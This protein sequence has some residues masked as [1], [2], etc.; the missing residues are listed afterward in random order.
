MGRAR[1]RRRRRVHRPLHRRH[2][3]A[4]AP[5]RGRQEGHHLGAGQER[6]HHH[7]HRRERRRLRRREA[8]H[9]LQR[10]V[11]HQLPRAVREG[12]AR[13][14]RHQARL[15]EHDPQLHQRPEHPRLA[16]QGPA[17]CARG[18][19]VDHPDL[20]RRRQGHRPRHAG[21]EGQARR[22]VDACSHAGRL[23]RRPGVRARDL[24][25]QR[26]HQRRDEGRCRRSDEGHPRVLRGADRLDRRR[27]QPGILGLRLAAD[28]GHGRGGHVR[29]VRL[30]VRQRVGLL[31]TASATSS[32]SSADEALVRR[33]VLAIEGASLGETPRS[34]TSREDPCSPRR[35]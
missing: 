5:R 28:D 34:Q 20:H 31:A 29:E 1:R 6:G 9:H 35:P 26:R 4:G 25:H 23:G 13:Q 7:R 10:V 21:H 2:Q 3:G 14:L 33:G 22:H 8:Q 30:V 11:H 27:R 17:P 24:G 32:R 16:A 15:H 18:R 12:A 19:D